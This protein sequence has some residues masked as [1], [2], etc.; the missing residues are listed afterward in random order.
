MYPCFASVHCQVV[1]HCLF[2]R[3]LVGGRLGHLQVLASMD[4]VARK[5]VQVDICFHL[6]QSSMAGAC[7]DS[8]FTFLRDWQLTAVT[9][10]FYIPSRKCPR[11][12]VTPHA[13]Q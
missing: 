7:G 6:T 12:P 4:N 9:A 10:P 1:F 2:T 11:V 13:H 3:L 5:I 8:V